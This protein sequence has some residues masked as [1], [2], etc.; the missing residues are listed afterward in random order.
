MHSVD[1]RLSESQSSQYRCL[2]ITKYRFFIEKKARSDTTILGILGIL[3]HFRH[4]PFNPVRTIH[5]TFV[6]RHSKSSFRPA[7]I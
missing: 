1:F 4:F 6:I 7:R 3:A 2:L 5:S